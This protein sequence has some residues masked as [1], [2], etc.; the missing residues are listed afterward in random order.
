MATAVVSFAIA[1]PLVLTMGPAS[2]V[3]CTQY[4]QANVMAADYTGSLGY[5]ANATGN[6]ESV[7][8]NS[9]VHDVC[10]RV[11][12]IF[13]QDTG[14][15]AFAE[16]G[17]QE[18]QQQALCGSGGNP[19]GPSV[20]LAW[21]TYSSPTIHCTMSSAQNPSQYRNLTIQSIT[22]PGV[23]SAFLGISPPQGIAATTQLGF[24]RGYALNNGER[25]NAGD[26]QY[27]QFAAETFITPGNT[28]YRAWAA[29]LLFYETPGDNYHC[30]VKASDSNFVQ[31]QPDTC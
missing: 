14:S 23:F 26:S 17:I 12:S 10:L 28:T 18:S 4:G 20:F 24:T 29:P 8:V 3:S 31:L 5:R 9:S 30:V 7:W 21:E 13:I 19:G 6:R 11:S 16:V 27:S 22:T 1:Y 2:A 25:H 15:P